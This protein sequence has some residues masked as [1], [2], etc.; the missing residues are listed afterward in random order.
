MPDKM[1][2]TIQGRDSLFAGAV[3]CATVSSGAAATGRKALRGIFPIA[4]RVH[5][6]VRPQNASEWES[7]TES[8]RWKGST[9]SFPCP[10]RT[11]PMQLPRL[12]II[13]KF[14]GGTD[15]PLFV[16]AAGSLRVEPLLR[17]AKL[18]ARSGG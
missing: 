11:S 18:P 9:P 5:G 14:G 8:E 2:D 15:L 10:R 16:Q 7:L 12:N 1:A 13:G 6:F 3:S 4:G 17:L